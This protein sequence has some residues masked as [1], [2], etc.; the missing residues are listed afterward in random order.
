M[1]YWMTQPYVPPPSSSSIN[2]DMHPVF[3][4]A[5]EYLHT[6]YAYDLLYHDELGVWKTYTSLS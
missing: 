3:F 5:A 6:C 1:T 4:I 2:I